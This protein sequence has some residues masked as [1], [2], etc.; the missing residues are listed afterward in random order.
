MSLF[1]SAARLLAFLGQ[2]RNFWP[3]LTPSVFLFLKKGETNFG[4]F[5]LL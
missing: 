3:L 5:G 1:S 4:F 2:I